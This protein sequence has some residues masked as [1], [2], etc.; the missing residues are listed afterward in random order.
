MSVT[1]DV[2]TLITSFTSITDR[3]K[4]RVHH[5]HM[6]ETS[7]YPAV[8]FARSS[9]EPMRTIDGDTSLRATRYSVECL[10][11]GLDEAMDLADDLTEALEGYRG[12]QGATTFQGVFVEDVDD[13]YIPL[14][15][16]SDEGINFAALQI[17][18]WH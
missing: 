13:D 14:N 5:N 9:R 7:E 2:R 3:V 6:P 1:E 18:V 4:E 10:S 11:T 16:A 17:A 8:F 12:T 15:D